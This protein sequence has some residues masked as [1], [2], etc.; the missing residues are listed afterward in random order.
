[1]KYVWWYFYFDNFNIEAV[2]AKKLYGGHLGFYIGGHVGKIKSTEKHTSRLAI[3]IKIPF[4]DS[5]L[6]DD[7]CELQYVSL[8]IRISAVSS[9]HYKLFYKNHV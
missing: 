2:I 6:P 7:S 1:M 9:G 3:K 4:S 5:S 8:T